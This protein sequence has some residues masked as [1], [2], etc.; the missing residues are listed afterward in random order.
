MQD[1]QESLSGHPT[2]LR[3]FPRQVT[4]SGKAGT[5]TLS[6]E[7]LAVVGFESRRARSFKYPGQLHEVLAKLKFGENLASQ[8]SQV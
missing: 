5:R 2:Q 4:K 6:V 8:D 3:N 1:C 7:R